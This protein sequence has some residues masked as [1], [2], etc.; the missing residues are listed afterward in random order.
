MVPEIYIYKFEEI[1]ELGKEICVELMKRRECDGQFVYTGKNAKGTVI[2]V[3]E[4]NMSGNVCVNRNS[5]FCLDCESRV[6]HICQFP[7]ENKL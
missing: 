3:D 1:P 5:G 7:I 2:K 6:R 4:R